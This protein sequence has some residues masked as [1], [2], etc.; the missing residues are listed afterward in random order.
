MVIETGS[1]REWRERERETERQR[2]RETDRGT[3]EGCDLTIP[4]KGTL[5][6]T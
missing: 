3:G 1:E 5:P 6:M 4:F 2:D